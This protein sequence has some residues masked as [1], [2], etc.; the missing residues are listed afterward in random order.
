MGARRGDARLSR[1][2][3]GRKRKPRVLVVCEGSK[4]EPIYIEGISSL[5]KEA[6]Y[7]L[8]IIPMGASPKTLVEEAVR[9]KKDAEKLARRDGDPNLL[10]ESVWVVFD[11]DEHPNLKEAQVQARGN[12]IEM[13]ISNPCFELWLLLHFRDQ[14]AYIERDVALKQLT[15]EMPGYKKSALSI[16]RILGR[17]AA[18]RAR[19]E[20]LKV[21]HENDGTAFPHDNPSSGIWELVECLRCPY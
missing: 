4:T 11:V 17:Y 10:F 19:A 3:A 12:N 2:Q 6:V 9:V 15:K 8:Q 5:S 18:A 13:A 14:A 7:Q 21:K 20:K 1:Q 16:D